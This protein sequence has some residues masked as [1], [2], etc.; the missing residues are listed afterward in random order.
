MTGCP[1]SPVLPTEEKKMALYYPE[2]P[3]AVN[4]FVL[5]DLEVAVFW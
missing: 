5:R 2:S 3:E 4:T 1:I